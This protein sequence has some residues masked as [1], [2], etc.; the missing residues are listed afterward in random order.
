MDEI[1][2]EFEDM[3]DEECFLKNKEKSL[4]IRRDFRIPLE[5]TQLV[6]EIEK[7]HYKVIN[8][9]YVGFK[10]ETE[11][12]KKLS[13]EKEYDFKLHIPND[14]ITGTCKIIYFQKNDDN[15]I[16]YGGVEI[17]SISESNH[18]KL[19]DYLAILKKQILQLGQ[20]DGQK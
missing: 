9:S 5:D 3:K 7:S 11:D 14:V 20:R 13:L 15:D 16:F 1:L 17:I 2:I 18:Q 12:I 4:G 6:V 8:I 19:K 10:I